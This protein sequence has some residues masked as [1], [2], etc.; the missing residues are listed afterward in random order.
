MNNIMIIK[1][2]S[3][4][5]H[6]SA[7]HKRRWRFDLVKLSSVLLQDEDKL[8]GLSKEFEA[9]GLV[10]QRSQPYALKIF[11]KTDSEPVKHDGYTHRFPFCDVFVMQ[12][13][14]VIIIIAICKTF[15]DY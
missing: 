9:E 11:D 1:S 5:V 3:N 2:F 7:G 15:L 4:I 10:I 12:V 13:W 14:H 6:R 8:F